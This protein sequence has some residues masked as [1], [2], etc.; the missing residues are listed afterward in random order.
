MTITTCSSTA[1]PH[2]PRLPSSPPLEL[3]Q[4]PLFL[5]TS[6]YACKKASEEA[7][8]DDDKEANA[9]DDKEA[10]DDDDKEA[11]DDGDEEEEARDI[12]SHT[13]ND[14]SWDGKAETA[15]KETGGEGGR[16]GGG[17]EGGEVGVYA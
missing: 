4:Q 2:A 1:M 16:G 9:D 15:I 17:R 14:Q 10:N 5:H 7:N 13:S 8:D 6:R 11:N 3:W 12:R